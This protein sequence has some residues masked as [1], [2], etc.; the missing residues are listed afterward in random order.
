[1]DFVPSMVVWFSLGTS[2]VL[3][4][5]MAVQAVTDP[6]RRRQFGLFAAVW[7]VLALLDLLHPH[8]DK[9]L[10]EIC[11]L[12]WLGGFTGS[13]MLLLG[14][15]LRVSLA[16][17][18]VTPLPGMAVWMM[19]RPESATTVG[20]AAAF[21][22]AAVVHG[23]QYRRGH[24]YAS[25]VLCVT[26]A[27]LALFQLIYHACV[28]A[29]DVRVLGLGYLH[30]AVMSLVS[31]LAG[32]VNLP[33]ELR[34]R[35]PVRVEPPL[36]VMMGAGVLLGEAGVMAGLLPFF[37]WPPVLYLAASAFQL[38]VILLFHFHHRH[39]LVIY[40]DNV[41]QLLEEQ[42][43]SLVEAQRQLS[44]QNEILAEKLSEQ[45]IALKSRAEVIERQRRLELAAQTA[46]QA[47]HDIQNVIAPIATYAEQLT[48]GPASGEEVRAAA[49]KIQRQVKH[50]TDLNG[51]MLALARRGRLNAVPV[52]LAE[53]AQEVKERF[54][55]A[56]L[57]LQVDGE[58][59]TLGS[60]SQLA[61]ALSNLVTNA[62]EAGGGAD[63]PVGIRTGTV[64]IDQPRPGH[65][66]FFAPGSYARVEVSDRGRGVSA[67]ALP[68]IFEPFY[69]SKDTQHR[70]GSGLGLSIVAAVVE[71][72]KGVLELQT[73][74]EGSVFALCFP[75]TGDPG[76]DSGADALCG[77]E[78]V[79]VTDDDSGFREE[80]T[81]ML[82]EAGYSVLTAADGVEALRVLQAQQVD[83]MILDVNMPRK[84]GWETQYGAIHLRPGIRTIVCSAFVSDEDAR[85]LREWGVSELLHKPAD[86]LEL[87]RKVR[88][89]L[90]EQTTLKR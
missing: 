37:S 13:L 22:L 55:G 34:R 53:L 17:L 79:L 20:F 70:S 18:V 61:R 52:N 7:L 57:R 42:T 90:D 76:S 11:R 75:R 50:L 73:S 46:G 71:D 43:G 19:G 26:A 47:A 74:P 16:V 49:E 63:V 24:G 58:A 66:G 1:M 36:A 27:V 3:G 10:Y 31:V 15:P 5:F 21:G 68:H 65:L 48:R 69:S 84:A 89:V 30:Y 33:R 64:T 67:E 38:T 87:L 77:N 86:R 51:Q 32:W 56:P 60:W 9:A 80:V 29:G 40:T 72:H 2:L 59:W 4:S 45:E 85:R 81:A 82:E 41:T 62:L 14:A 23:I 88:G 12:V 44:R 25:A 39:Q 83:V 78:T 6:P 35:A 28:E 8:L 54:P